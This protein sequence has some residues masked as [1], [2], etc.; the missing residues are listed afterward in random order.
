M[1]R[2]SELFTFSVN[3]KD[4]DW[5]K[6]IKQQ[7]CPYTQKRCFKVRKSDADISIGT[8]IVKNG[9]KLDNIII[10]PHRLLERKQIFIDC[11]HLMTRHVPGN[12]L[13]IIPEVSIPGGNVDYFIVSTDGNRKVKDF[14]GVELQ[15][16]DTTGTVW[17]ERQKAVQELGLQCEGVISNKTFGMN[18]KMTAKTILVQLHHKIKT[19]ENLDRHFVLVVQEQLLN[20][21]KKEFYFNH[22]SQ[23][24]LIG[25]TM[26]FHSYGLKTVDNQLK[27]FLQERYSTDGDGISQLLGLNAD[28]NVEFDTIAKILESKVSDKTIF[29]IG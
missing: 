13:H 22:I 29:T 11:L 24:P 15:T 21:I 12:E 7:L 20:Y 1:S 27:L 2:V 25:D 3:R 14:I 4:I 16:M 8:C 17:P 6:V 26:H 9:E 19:F 23:H 28:A 10:C 5:E 18:W